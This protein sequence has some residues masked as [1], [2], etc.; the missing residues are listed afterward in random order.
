MIVFWQIVG[1]ALIVLGTII[2]ATASYY[3][4]IESTKTIEN[5]QHRQ[6]LTGQLETVLSE[7][8]AGDFKRTSFISLKQYMDTSELSSE[9]FWSLYEVYKLSKTKTEK[10]EI[11]I[12]LSNFTWKLKQYPEYFKNSPEVKAELRVN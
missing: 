11:Q 8:K 4:H 7:I 9:D 2:G 10:P 3:A 5:L 1:A 6:S 12:Y